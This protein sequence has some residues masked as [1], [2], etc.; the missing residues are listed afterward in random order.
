[1]VQTRLEVTR[2]LLVV[3]EGIDQG[4][5]EVTLRWTEQPNTQSGEANTLSLEVEGLTIAA[6]EKTIWFDLVLLAWTDRRPNLQ[7]RLRVG[8]LTIGTTHQ[9]SSLH[10]EFFW[11]FLWRTLPR[12]D[13]RVSKLT[14]SARER[15]PESLSGSGEADPCPVG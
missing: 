10:K 5:R 14:I 15:I 6:K 2:R 7:D 3:L 13:G 4:E 9:V 1:M 8:A 12:E 11:T